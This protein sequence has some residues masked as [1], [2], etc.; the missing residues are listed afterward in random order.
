MERPYNSPR[1]KLEREGEK[2]KRREKKIAGRPPG[3]H[4]AAKNLP[5]RPRVWNKDE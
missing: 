2:V 5:Q 4:H 1:A 3:S